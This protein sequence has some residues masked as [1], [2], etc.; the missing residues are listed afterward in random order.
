MMIAFFFIEDKEESFCL[1]KK[2]FLL[3]DINI[4]VVLGIFILTLNNIEI[5]F[6]SYNLY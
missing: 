4:N 2:T 6:A 5:N 1:F 3:I